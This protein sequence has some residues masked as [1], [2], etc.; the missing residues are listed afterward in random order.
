MKMPIWVIKSMSASY[1]TD[2]CHQVGIVAAYEHFPA[3]LS[4]FETKELKNV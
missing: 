4:A 1:G 2:I 3:F